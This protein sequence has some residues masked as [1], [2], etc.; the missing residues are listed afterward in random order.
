MADQLQPLDSAQFTAFKGGDEKALTGVFRSQYDTLVAQAREAL[1]P[2]LAHFGGRVAQQAML[3]TWA[4]RAEF[5]SAAG[6]MSALQEA[7]V[8]ESGQQ[9]RRHAALHTRQGGASHAPHVS[10]MSADEAAAKLMEALHPA[11]VD[12][13]KAVDEV[14]AARKH[15]AAQ[16]VNKVG[17]GRGWKG[18]TALI[19]VLGVVIV[20]GMKM[21]NEGGVDIAVTKALAADD[22]RTLSSQRGQRGTVDL[23]DGS[24]AKIGSDSKL[25]LPV[26]F[27][28]TMRTLQLTGTASFTVA[29]GQPLPFTV[30][31]ANVIITATGTQF[32]VL[33]YEEDSA[34]VV[35]VDEGSVSVR[36][37][38]VNG[39]TSV[40]AGKAVRVAMDGSVKDLDDATR[41]Q[42]FA[43]V[44]DTLSFTNTPV[45]VVLPQLGRWFDVKASLADAALGERPVTMVLGMQSSG[46]ALKMMAT[47]ANLV[48]AFDK[49]DKVVLRDA[50]PAPAKKK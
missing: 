11:P 45:K 19:A 5:D 46:E 8:G 7:I 38:D 33:A 48:I 27:G 50:G 41:S 1:G 18:P 37:K 3:G 31:A 30:R 10:A 12:H 21:L 26:E 25:R 43:W 23:S 36:T 13:A 2:E 14:A 17:K 9:R 39:E 29:A 24:K 32:T 15:H 34:V 35:S 44:R 47:A 4:R 16:H 20:Y 42:T 49:D 40:A 6:L 28:G 22:A